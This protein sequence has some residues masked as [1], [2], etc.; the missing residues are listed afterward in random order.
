VVDPGGADGEV[1]AGDQV[2]G[3][4]VAGDTEGGALQAWVAAWCSD[5]ES[6]A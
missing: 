6:T 5:V 2:A 4:Q 3:D 1:R